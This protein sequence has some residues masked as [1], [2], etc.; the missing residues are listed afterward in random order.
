[1]ANRP[2]IQS[3]SSSENKKKP[4]T[5][6]LG[7]EQLEAALNKALDGGAAALP[8]Q[9][10]YILALSQ[11]IGASGV[12]GSQPEALMSPS[13]ARTAAIVSLAGTLE[14]KSL[15]SLFRNVS[16]INDDRLRLSLMAELALHL[17]SAEYAPIMLDAW[18][19]ARHLTDRAA[20]AEMMLK[21]APLVLLTG[22]EPSAS[23]DLLDLVALAQSIANT[24]ARVR[25]LVALS[26]HLPKS[27]SLRLMNRILDDIEENNNDALR[28]GTICAIAAEV[29]PEIEGRV[30][31]SAEG[32]RLPIERARALTALAATLSPELL[33]GLRILALGSIAAIQNEEDRANA[34]VAFAP[35]LEYATEEAEFP[36]LLQHALGIAVSMLRRQ[37]RARALVSLAPRLTSDLQG[38]ALAAVHSLSSER[39]RAT[40]LA[41][42]APTLPPD[43]LVASLAVAHTMREQDARV[44]ALTV[45]AHHVPDHARAQTLLDALAAAANLPHHYE[46][47]TALIALVDVLPPPLQEQAYTNALE[48]TRLIDNENARSRALSLLGH[49]LPPHLITRALDAAYQIEDPQQRLNALLGIVPRLTDETQREVRQSALEHM[50]D[51][52]G[53]MAFEYKKARALVSIA[54]QLTEDTRE[55]AIELVARFSDPFDRATAY[56]ALAQNQPPEARPKLITKAWNLIKRIEDGYDRA[57][58][59]AAIGP[60]LPPSARSELARAANLVV[61]L[62]MDDYDQASAITIL[63]PLMAVGSL[64]AQDVVGHEAAY[65]EAVLA[66]LDV[67]HQAARARLLGESARLWVELDDAHRDALWREV[68]ARLPLLPLADVLL[69]LGQ[70]T[71]LFHA[72]AG[73]DGLQRIARILG[74]R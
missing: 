60:Y 47:V 10:R 29:R 21:L 48:A 45:L 36:L 8:S 55:Q 34:L 62:I 33:P 2:G 50:L 17:P 27:M 15:R 13:Q 66:A 69:C 54:P 49:Y 41:E 20:R 1:M 14:A 46:R 56:I 68:A 57:S 25:S 9:I 32:I 30:L 58:A 35:Y 40:L 39:D 6:P 65:R 3:R 24:E 28:A 26:P 73:E 37:L 5:A 19:E 59:L 51:A 7:R 70:L 22:D 23:R 53:D 72:M 64:S 4:D 18:Q 52:A 67:P 38:E 16:Q 63:A 71:P 44:H 11:M 74:I 12:A 42:L 31:R 43:M 61:G